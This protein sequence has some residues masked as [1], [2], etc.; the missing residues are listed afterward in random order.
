MIN[1]NILNEAK[2]GDIQA[3]H[4]LFMPFQ[5]KLKSFLFRLAANP[6]D[7]DD[8]FQEIYLKSFEKLSTFKGNSTLKTWVFKIAINLARNKFNQEQRWHRNTF[9]LVRDLAHSK[10]EYMYELEYTNKNSSHG[11]F[12]IKEHIDYCFTCIGKMLPL[13]QQ[14]AVILKKLYNFKV[15]EIA[16]IVDNTEGQVKHLLH[17][18]RKTMKEIFNDLCAIVNKKGICFQCSGLNKRFN[19]KEDAREKL[20]QIKLF[21]DRDVLNEN[22]LLKLRVELIKGINPHK[23]SGTDL[24]KV[25]F[26]FS[27]LVN[28]KAS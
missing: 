15:K 12:E 13:D 24:H 5:E 22:K 27:R 10:P 7:V 11:F 28:S 14:I 17:D 3:F 2:Q 21:R 1:E 26:K 16:L 4:K 9:N 6:D 18:G 19:P 20:M 25:F 8:L 23:N